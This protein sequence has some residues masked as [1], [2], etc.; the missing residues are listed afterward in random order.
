[1]HGVCKRDGEA[2]RKWL[3]GFLTGNARKR[4][5]RKDQRWEGF[6]DQPERLESVIGM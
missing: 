1:M 4:R 6:Q 5:D 3:K 2:R